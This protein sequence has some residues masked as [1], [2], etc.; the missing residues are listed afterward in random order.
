MSQFHLIL[1]SDGSAGAQKAA[2]WIRQHFT[3]ET[4]QVTVLT[5]SHNPV[6]LGS[7]D[8]APTP[9]YSEALEDAAT[10]DA[11]DAAHDTASWL[12]DFHPQVMVISGRS[13]VPAIIAYVEQH[14]A[15]AIVIGR[16][17]H[18]LVHNL[19]V[20]SVS[21]GLISESSIPVWLIP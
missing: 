10:N 12:Q 5:V 6:D 7:S 19:L 11:R 9:A 16:R 3:A 13:I 1:A 15:D 18:S 17:E 2:E 20:G 14:P 8:F 4:A 21:S